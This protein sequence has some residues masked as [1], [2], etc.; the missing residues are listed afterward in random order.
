MAST[1]AKGRLTMAA[2]KADAAR[3]D[4]LGCG[5]IAVTCT[6]GNEVDVQGLG[7]KAVKNLNVCSRH[8]NWPHSEDAQ[9]FALT[10]DAY[11]SRK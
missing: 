6:D 9:K 4:L 7:R 2:P 11:K 8:G 1:R 5:M 10:S 3:C